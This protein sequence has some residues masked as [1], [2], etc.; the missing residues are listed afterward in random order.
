VKIRPKKRKKCEEKEEKNMRR[1]EGA[2][3]GRKFLCQA[4]QSF[5]LLWAGKGPKLTKQKK[6]ECFTTCVET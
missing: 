5:G 6:L 4:I 2:S 3:M 1:G